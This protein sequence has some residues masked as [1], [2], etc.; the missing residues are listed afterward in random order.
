MNE[1]TNDVMDY[2]SEEIEASKVEGKTK[3]E[4][5]DIINDISDL[6]KEFNYLYNWLNDNGVDESLNSKQVML[7]K[8]YNFHIY[9]K[10]QLALE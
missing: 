6:D 8:K 7:L 3:K 2:Y 9:S 4:I 10:V 5:T 1:N